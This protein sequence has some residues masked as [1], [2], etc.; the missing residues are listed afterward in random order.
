LAPIHDHQGRNIGNGYFMS[1]TKTTTDHNT[2]KRWAEKR[3]GVPSSVVGTGTGDEAGILR[4]DFEPKDE[5]LYAID[6]D[7]FFQ[8][9]LDGRPGFPVLGK[10]GRRIDQPFS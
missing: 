3:G 2:I 10:D 4:L 8:E 6:W 9:V 1:D 7:E 5:K